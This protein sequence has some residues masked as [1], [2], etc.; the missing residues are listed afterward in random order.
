MKCTERQTK[1]DR[2]GKTDVKMRGKRNRESGLQERAERQNEIIQ[3]TKENE[4]LLE[5]T[6]KKWHCALNVRKMGREDKGRCGW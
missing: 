4:N 6:G 5:E 2:K 3:K 1:E